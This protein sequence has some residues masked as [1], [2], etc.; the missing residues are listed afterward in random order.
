[1][2]YRTDVAVL[3]QFTETRASTAVPYSRHPIVLSV[4]RRTASPRGAR[5]VSAELRGRGHDHARG[6]LDHTQGA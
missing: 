1:V 4:H 5:S 6:G 2:D 3:A